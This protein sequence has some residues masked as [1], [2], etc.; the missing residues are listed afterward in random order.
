MTYYIPDFKSNDINS[1]EFKPVRFHMHPKPNQVLPDD[2]SFLS[3][4]TP[5]DEIYE[6]TK[7]VIK[8]TGEV[9]IGTTEVAKGISE[10]TTGQIVN[11]TTDIVSGAEEVVDDVHDTVGGIDEIV[12][13]IED[14][15]PSEWFL[16]RKAKKYYNKIIGYI[17]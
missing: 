17:W 1:Y 4:E 13:G 9:V 7:K 3:D 14:T 15:H 8:G 12:H 10:V 11:G 16:Y 2:D 6:G 5:A